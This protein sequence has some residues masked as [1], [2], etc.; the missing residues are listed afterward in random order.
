MTVGGRGTDW[1]RVEGES[2]ERS[3]YTNGM[4]D[5][6]LVDGYKLVEVR[7][8]APGV[9]EGPGGSISLACRSATVFDWVYENIHQGGFFAA[10]GN[11]GGSAQIAFS[12]AYYGIDEILDLA[13]LSGGPPPCPIT[14]EGEV[15]KEEQ[16]KCL[17]EAELWNESREPM[18]FGNPRLH[19]PNTVV[20]FFL[21]EH[22]RSAEIIETANAYHEAITSE[23]SIQIVPNTPHGVHHTAEGTAAL[24]TSINPQLTIPTAALT[25]TAAPDEGPTPVIATIPVGDDPQA[26]RVNPSTN[27]VYVANQGD[28]TVSVI[29]GA[30]N[31]VIVTVPVGDKPFA[32]G[33]N[34]ATGRVYVTNRDEDTV[35]VIDGASNAV[36]A[37]IPVGASPSNAVI[38]TIPV[39]ASPQA[40]GVNATTSRVY[41]ASYEDGTVSVMDGVSNTVIA[42]VPVD[43]PLGVG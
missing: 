26:V 12:L 16:L 22:E 38:A 35:S 37:T 23:K 24:T 42:T 19:Y 30:S 11:S 41:V 27:R 32:I 36:I 13:N 28:D 6:L 2:V 3:G 18:L 40:I 34:S 5:T 9:W 39:G 29:D 4:M 21:G 15:N 10:Q 1:Y 17:V 14:T 33:V 7:W 25:P 8:V 43:S 20:R 31:A